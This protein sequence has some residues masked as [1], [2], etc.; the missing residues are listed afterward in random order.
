[1]SSNGDEEKNQPQ[2]S[3][4]DA[5][6][7]LEM[8]TIYYDISEQVDLNSLPPDS[9]SID[10]SMSRVNEIP[11]FA[12]FT[13][14]GAVCFRNNLLKTLNSEHL[15]ADKGLQV[16]KDLDFYDKQIEKIENLDELTTLES[17]DLSFNRLKK[18]ENL[19]KLVNLKKL[20]LV[21]NHVN[22]IENLDKLI[23]LEMLELGD[24][25]LRQLE[26]LDQLKQLKQL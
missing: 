4:V 13:C 7:K 18:I 11:N 12:R 8:Q 26:N 6:K 19:D 21:H 3:A 5:K 24:N 15:A 2:I 14:L 17:L 20:Y 16:I 25:Q 23:N 9:D 10:L 1:M 22:K